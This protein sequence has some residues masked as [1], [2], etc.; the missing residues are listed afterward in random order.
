MVPQAT[1]VFLRQMTMNS[2]TE[3]QRILYLDLTGVDFDN[4][5]IS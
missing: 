3:M 4:F 2:A 5:L 1:F